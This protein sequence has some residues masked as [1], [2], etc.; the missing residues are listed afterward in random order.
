MKHPKV[1]ISTTTFFSF[2][3][4]I[5]TAAAQEA[6]ATYDPLSRNL[7]VAEGE[8]RV[9]VPVNAFDA[10]F[11]F[12]VEKA[13]FADAQKE[14]ERIAS[15]IE[16]NTKDL[17]LQNVEVLKGWDLIRQGRIS[18]TS[19]AK[20]LSNVVTVRV[21]DF[22]KGKLHEFI[23]AITDRAL[24][25]DGAVA[26]KN[27]RVY[28]TETV[29]N[30]RR[31]EASNQALK[32]LQVNADRMAGSL[33]RKVKAVKRVYPS[34]MQ[35]RA[36]MEDKYKMESYGVMS[37]MQSVVSIQKSFKV[38]S[39]VTDHLEISAAVSGLYEIE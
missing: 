2:V 21:T 14:S 4:L 11:D 18:F 36:A 15:I 8:S 34:V 1:K 33:G 20:K 24:S 17:G 30:E 25:A 27:I 6:P 23:A 37:E 28:L 16:V 35:A 10:V 38:E 31:I 29:E 19:K 3:L 5:G 9:T 39:E 13:T 22:P 32:A 7:I 26:L 12:D